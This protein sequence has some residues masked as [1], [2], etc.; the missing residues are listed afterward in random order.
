MRPIV[1][2]FVSVWDGLAE[3]LTN[4]LIICLLLHS[5][6]WDLDC[7]QH[8]RESS[9]M[10]Y[11]LNLPSRGVPS[12]TCWDRLEPLSLSYFVGLTMPSRSLI[13]IASIHCIYK[14]RSVDT[15]NCIVSVILRHCDQT[16]WTKG[17]TSAF[18]TRL[19]IFGDPT[20]PHHSPEVLSLLRR[21]QNPFD[22]GALLGEDHPFQV[23]VAWH[24]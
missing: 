19:E 21:N 4:I 9:R 1:G 5:N 2:I 24:M 7:I 18:V 3:Q 23:P 16:T 12:R 22:H 11:H 8:R 6:I 13:W 10:G 17:V 14:G 20:Y 15:D